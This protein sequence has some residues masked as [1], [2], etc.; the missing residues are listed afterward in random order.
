MGSFQ[1]CRGVLNE[2]HDKYSWLM[3]AILYLKRER[4]CDD[5]HA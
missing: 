5:V 1:G 2:H 4:F 3:L